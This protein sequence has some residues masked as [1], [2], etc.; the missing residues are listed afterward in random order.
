MVALSFSL[1]SWGGQGHKT[2]SLHAAYSFKGKMK[3]FRSFFDFIVEHASDPDKRK[4]VD[5]TEGKKHYI[6][7][8]N[9][10]EYLSSGK[11]IFS[12]E[13]NVSLHGEKFVAKNGTLP[14]A[15]R[16]SYDSLVICLKRTDLDKAKQF[17][18]DL[19]HYVAD[20]HMP[21]HTSRNYDGQ[22]TDNKGIHGRYESTMV[23]AAYDELKYYKIRRSKKV[24]DVNSYILDYLYESNTYV[25]S[26][27]H[28]D[29]YAQKI[30]KSTESDAYIAALWLKTGDLT[31]YLLKHASQAL[32]NLYYTAWVEA[33]K[34]K[35]I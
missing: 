6:D 18:A 14:W 30:A 31:Q 12:Y 11:I 23:N 35:I 8:D 1:M 15:T 9:Y 33:G 4:S 27:M 34:P 25:D 28:A 10:D 7:V 2:I 32:A 17:A 5:K 16:A 13:E 3:P 19:G 20:G 22:F 26:I 29:D 24:A 21:L